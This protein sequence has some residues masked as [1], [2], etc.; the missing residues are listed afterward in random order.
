MIVVAKNIHFT[1]L[2][3]HDVDVDDHHTRLVFLVCRVAKL[4]QQKKSQ[5]EYSNSHK[6]KTSYPLLFTSSSPMEER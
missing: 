3:D 2:V 1:R 6:L 4:N 5:H